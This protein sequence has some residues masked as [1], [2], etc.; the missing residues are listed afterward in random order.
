[1][2]TTLLQASATSPLQHSG[3]L[4]P[5]MDLFIHLFVYCIGRFI[6][7]SVIVHYFVLSVTLCSTLS[8]DKPSACLNLVSLIARSLSFSLYNT[9]HVFLNPPSS[10]FLFVTSKYSRQHFGLKIPQR[11]FPL[12]LQTMEH[13]RIKQKEVKPQF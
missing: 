12:R 10:Y 1:V 5:Q 7:L 6:D 13:T 2:L 8:Y 3:T 9:E 4:L 11:V